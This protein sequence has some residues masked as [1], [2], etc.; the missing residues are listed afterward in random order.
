VEAGLVPI[1]VN[2]VTPRMLPVRLPESDLVEQMP[3]AYSGQF[4]SAEVLGVY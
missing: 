2:V 1:L 3:Q 4:V